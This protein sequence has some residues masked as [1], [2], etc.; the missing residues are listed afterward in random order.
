MSPEQAE[1]KPVDARSD[2]FSFGLVFYEMLSGRRAF[3]GDSAIAIMAAILHKE[4]EPLDATPALKTILTRCLRKSPADRFQSMTQVKEALL[5]ASGVSS[6]ASAVSSSPQPP[7]IPSIAV[8]PFTNMSRDADDEYFSDGL[9]EEISNLLAHVSGLKVIARTSA[10]AFKGKNEDIRKIAETLGVNNVLEGSVRRAGNRLRITAQLIQAAD[11]SHL[12]SERYDREM[13]DVFAIQDEI[14]QA[15]TAAL[16]LT[17]LISTVQQRYQPNLPAYEAFLKARHQWAKLTP[18]SMA[19]S[20]EYYEQAIALD[21]KFA[22]AHI[23]LADYF[24]LLATG[25]G[26]MPGREAMPLVRAA[27]Q[28]ALEI[29]PMLP[30]A[31]AMLGIVAGVYDYDW[32][33]A[34]RLFRLAMA[35]DPVPPLVHSWY[36]YFFLLLLGRVGNAVE[37]TERSLQ[38]DP[39]NLMSRVVLAHCLSAAGRY[40]DSCTEC[41]RILEFDENHWGGYAVLAVNL[42][43]R[44]RSSEALALAEKAYSLSPWNTLSIAVFAAALRQGGDSIRAEEVLQPL[45]TTPQ[46]YGAPRGLALFHLFFGEFDQTPQ[47][48]E[49]SIEQRDPYAP[50]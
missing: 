5:A 33:E 13:T 1:A 20:K 32:K 21:P 10:F 2:I 48:L 46:A 19:R 45:R 29:D 27:A 25:A 6:P 24:L 26:L 42:L 37:E 22:L 39:L 14:A 18:E 16:K 44:E 40:E 7:P 30:E 11:G 36:G 15:I 12:W 38:E 35:R 8:L 43:L 50:F 17:L 31:H 34:E 3:T 41:R 23:G 49:K 47:W 28:R 4:P 9:A